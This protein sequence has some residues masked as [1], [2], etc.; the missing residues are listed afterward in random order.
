[1][2]LYTGN[3]NTPFALDVSLDGA[4]LSYSIRAIMQREF[5][6]DPTRRHPNGGLYFDESRVTEWRGDY[7]VF[8]DPIHERSINV[9]ALR[10]HPDFGDHAAFM[11]YAPVG[12][13]ADQPSRES[14]YAQTPN[15]YAMTISS[16][17]DAQAYHATVLQSHPLGQVLVP[18][19]SSPIWDWS[20][21]FNVYDPILLRVSGDLE[22]VPAIT[23]VLVREETLPV[24]RFIGGPEATVAASDELSIS[25][26]LETPDGSPIVDQEAEVFLDAT[27]GYL[28]ARRV[29]TVGGVG[30][31]TF[32]PDGLA[33]GA[34]AK[35]KVG[36]KLFSGT[37]D[38]TVA[39]G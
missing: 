8:G 31:T 5:V 19:R 30:R 37:D 11:L 28:V 29:T 26:R 12:V 14:F 15:L 1:M 36:F 3:K 18:L 6:G 34:S 23:L 38:L 21:G 9:E 16:K 32:R 17:M 13:A 4:T 27:G 10:Q 35:I 2:K 24:V 7:A 39:I 25:F 22:I 33:S 20:L